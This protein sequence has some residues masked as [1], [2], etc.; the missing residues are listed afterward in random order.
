MNFKISLAFKLALFGLLLCF[1]ISVF[2]QSSE[3]L[4]ITAE[5]VAEDKTFPLD[6]AAWKYRAGDDQSWAAK[7]FDDSDWETL[8]ESRINAQVLPASG[9]NG[10]GWFRVRLQIDSTA[11]NRNLVL[12]GRQTGASEVYLDGRLIGKFGEI[13]EQGETEF[14]PNNL[15]LPFKFDEPG[16]HVLA[17]RFSSSVFADLNKGAAAWM[18]NGGIKPGFSFFVKDA[19]DLAETVLNYRNE[20]SARPGFFFMGVLLALSF[21]HFLLFAFYRAERGNLFYSIYAASFAVNMLCGNTLAFNNQ[22]IFSRSVTGIVANAAITVSF[23][24]LL[25]FLHVAFRRRLGIVFWLIVALHLISLVSFAVFL[26]NVGGLQLFATAAIFG[27]ISLSIFLL[28][29]AMMEKR[30][31]AWT[32]MIGMQ[33]F[34]LGMLS[35]LVNQMQWLKLP[36]FARELGGFFLLLGIPVAVSFFLARNFARTNRDLKKQLEE[37]KQLSEQK[38]EQERQAVE[39]RAENER[40]A[41]ELEEARQLQLSMLPKKLPQIANLE[42]AAYMK[43]AT[44]VGGDYYDF[45]VGKDGTLTAVIG[46][47]TGHGLKAG[48]VVTAT[49]SLFNAFAEEENIGQIFGQTSKALKKM[50][51]RG[52]FMAMAMLKIRDN[53]VA[54]SVAGMP[55]MLIYRAASREIEEIAIRAMPLGSVTNFSYQERELSLSHGDVLVLM[56]DGFPEMFNAAGEMLADDEAKRVLAENAHLPSQEIINRFVKVGENWAGTRP[57]DDDV[58]FVILKVK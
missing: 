45:Y 25:A 47:A 3:P 19:A 54:V 44:E 30:P 27:T 8:Q 36:G 46:D 24:S 1:P 9:W 12:S 2:A 38:I 41:K 28:V 34:G 43:P 33:L 58:T 10:R 37:V 11:A 16:E 32:L 5:S 50:N 39:L 23:I 56:S 13:Y 21:L 18:T 22:S 29:R 53:R 26:N 48:S 15:P 49:K 6:K 20:T 31:G 51:L 4:I 42:I 35:V 52:L 7:N 57:P 40:R 14:N 17:V 55:P